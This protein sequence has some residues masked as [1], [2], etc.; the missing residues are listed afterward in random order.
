[1]IGLNC[2]SYSVRRM[3]FPICYGA[4]AVEDS[5][6]ELFK[7]GSVLQI[8]RCPDVIVSVHVSISLYHLFYVLRAP[9]SSSLTDAT[10]KSHHV[11]ND[12]GQTEHQHSLV[13]NK[14][15]KIPSILVLRQ[16]LKGQL[17]H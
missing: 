2:T 10:C 15:Q 13:T 12:G 9:A 4:F 11:N 6:Q 5:K 7:A 1:M 8:K 16:I 3:T 14:V 17:A